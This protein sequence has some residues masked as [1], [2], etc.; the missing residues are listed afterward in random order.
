MALDTGNG[1][2]EEDEKVEEEEE[3]EE[4][5]AGDALVRLLVSASRAEPNPT[6]SP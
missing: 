3:E 4:D 5:G 2:D 1:R 6:S